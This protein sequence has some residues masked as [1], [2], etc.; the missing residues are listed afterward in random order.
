MS[1]EKIISIE[2]V[3]DSQ[4]NYSATL[5]SARTSS[6]SA[7][8]K[9]DDD[10]KKLTQ[11]PLP[12]E[13]TQGWRWAPWGKGD[14]LPTNIRRKIKKVPL[15]GQVLKKLV[16][17]MYGNGI[18][19]YRNSDLEEGNVAK[20]ARVN[21]VEKWLKRNRVNTY[22][23]PAQILDYSQFLI[24]F[25][26]MTLSKDRKT[27]AR[28]Y[29]KTAPHCRLSVQDEKS[30]DIEE[31]LYSPD[32]GV[33]QYPNGDRIKSIPLFN[34]DKQEEFMER[35]GKRRGKK[36]AWRSYFETTG[37]TYY[38]S[39]FWEG[40]FRE[41]GWMDVSASVPEIVHAM[42]KNQIRI[43]YL[44]NIPESYF[45]IR[46]PEW[47]SFTAK[48]RQEI[49]DELIDKIESELT[50]TKNAF[51]SISSVFRESA[52]QGQGRGKIEI[53]AMDDKI[54]RDSWVPSSNAADAQIAQSLGLHPSQIGLAPEGGKMGAGSGSDQR[55]SFNST[56]STNT[57]DQQI[58][59]QQLQ[60]IADYN[61]MEGGDKIVN[62]DWDITFY[63]DHTYHT[64]TNDQEDGMQK[65]SNK[66]LIVE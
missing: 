52:M 46:H 35:L 4:G 29:H 11:A 60:Y 36:F 47:H 65:D 6:G 59:L 13:E 55:E 28:I 20:R 34:W 9:T 44:I 10:P 21:T 33:Q 26:E 14:C 66:N 8:P 31:L 32:F 23:L 57:I 40:L 56:I 25:S 22:F 45:E 42:A 43:A 30:L 37:M 5:P 49:I 58:L 51:K 18:A 27:I 53:I 38:P 41:D 50:D 19:Y 62:Q 48:K 17:M 54:K 1:N 64:T 39:P 15:A 61:A 16:S 63:I 3:Q 24:C 7:T 12:R 2:V